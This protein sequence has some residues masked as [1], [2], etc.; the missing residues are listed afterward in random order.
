VARIGY[1]H[2]LL[3]VATAGLLASGCFMWRSADADV[4]IWNEMP[5]DPRPELWAE[6]EPRLTVVFEGAY[7]ALGDAQPSYDAQASEYFLRVLRKNSAFKEVLG[8][9]AEAS[10]SHARV[11]VERLYRETENFAENMM[12]AA[13]IPGVL[14]Y[15]YDLVGTLRL[16]LRSP[17]GDPVTYE[18]RSVLRRVYHSA[19]NRDNARR[20]AFYE[21]DRANIDAVLHQ[22]R[23]DPALFEAGAPGEGYAD[24]PATN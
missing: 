15:H 17:D 11:R 3:S 8:R 21:V 16:E 1:R 20:L 12:K 18:A 7:R 2:T 23:A 22:L 13:T 9:D 19:G 6:G 4:T 5:E 14:G 10:G 24:A